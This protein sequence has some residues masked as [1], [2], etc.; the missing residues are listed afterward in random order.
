MADFNAAFEHILEQEGGWQITNHPHD[1]GGMTFAGISRK[2]NP[3]W[4]GWNLIDKGASEAN[5]DLHKRARWLYREKY[6]K[7][8]QLDMVND[9]GIALDIFSCCVLSGQRKAAILTQIAVK[10]KPDGVVGPNTIEAI[11]EMDPEL[12]DL[13]FCITRIIRYRDIVQSDKSQ[14][15]WFLGW[16]NRALGGLA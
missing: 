1:R 7:P 13:R 11:N 15:K 8:L 4:T 12:W 3:D 6:W 9:L 5:E 16:V 2:A 10:S 14:R